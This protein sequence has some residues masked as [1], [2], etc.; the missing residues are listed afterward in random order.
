MSS[1]PSAFSFPQHG[2][3]VG[4]AMS[5]TLWL[6]WSDSRG[7]GNECFTFQNDL[8]PL[9]SLITEL[10]HFDSTD[11]SLWAYLHSQGFSMDKYSLLGIVLHST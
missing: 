7:E 3:P 8:T 11:I 10:G 1:L 6:P 2:S 9:P 5:G 4:I